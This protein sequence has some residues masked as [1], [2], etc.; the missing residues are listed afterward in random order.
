MSKKQ[1]SRPW[2]YL[3]GPYTQGDP[4][5]NVRSMCK[6]FDRLMN[7]G[8]VYPYAPLW[9]HFQHIMFPRQ[10]SDWLNYDLEIIKR[11]DACLFMP[12]T[13]IKLDYFQTESTGA[14]LEIIEFEKQGKK[15]FYSLNDLYDWT[16]DYDIK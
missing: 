13:D 10:Y 15:V 5:I 9:S 2:I 4:A 3:S 12:S 6:V 1:D 11:M 16:K 8:I 14:D 7:D